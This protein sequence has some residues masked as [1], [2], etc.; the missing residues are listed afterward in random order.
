M[1]IK[2][3]LS[4]SC[5]PARFESIYL[6]IDSL[7][8]QTLKPDKIFLSIPHRFKRFPNV[9][10]NIDKLINLNFNNLQII[11]CDDFGPGTSLIGPLNQLKDYNCI[12]LLND[13]HVYNKKM[14]EIFIDKFKENMKAAYSFFIYHIWGIPIAQTAD[15]FLV[16]TK[17]LGGI[18][19]FYNKHV[20][21]NKTLFLNDDF[22]L[23]IY[24]NKIVD[25]KILSLESLIKERTGENFIYKQH[26]KHNALKD[27][28]S[29][30]LSRRT[31]A[32]IDF[33]K[34]LFKERFFL[35]KLKI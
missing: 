22:W 25:T 19:E 12:I 33:I 3:C 20:S 26:T 11:R 24:L 18:G 23:S 10:V 4:L 32:K 28:Y 21:S 8:Q 27:I 14:C 1:K 2:F 6:T 30:F 17:L 7:Q 16:N 29:P 9:D 13:D 31:Y 15:G 35:N 5:V 34:I